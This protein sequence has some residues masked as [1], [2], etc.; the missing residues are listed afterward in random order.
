MRA[1]TESADVAEEGAVEMLES[2]TPFRKVCRSRWAAMI[3]KVYEVDP[4][5]CPKCGGG[6]MRIIAFIEPLASH[7]M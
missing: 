3:K 7:R 5:V 4:L 2:D 1:R 6:R